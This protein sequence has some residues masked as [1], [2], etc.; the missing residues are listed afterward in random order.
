MVAYNENGSVYA[1]CEIEM[2][3]VIEPTSQ[4]T[5]ACKRHSRATV[6]GWYIENRTSTDCSR[7][8]SRRSNRFAIWPSG[9]GDALDLS[10][11]SAMERLKRGVRGLRWDCSH[12]RKP[13]ITSANTADNIRAKA[14]AACPKFSANWNSNNVD[15]TQQ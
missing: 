6:T 9:W 5:L 14:Q 3:P 2:R 10:T 4:M 1:T 15:G 7:I 12:A 13:I 8:R 11:T